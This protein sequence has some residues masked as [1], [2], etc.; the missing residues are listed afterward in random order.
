MRKSRLPLT[1]VNTPSYIDSM[2]KIYPFFV[3]LSLCGMLIIQA[4]ASHYDWNCMQGHM[5]GARLTVS[6]VMCYRDAGIGREYIP[7]AT[8]QDK[9]QQRQERMDCEAKHP[10]DTYICDPRYVPPAPPEQKS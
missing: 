1:N 9:L 4:V 10:T 5:D 7:W 8:I 2:K 3:L 6:G